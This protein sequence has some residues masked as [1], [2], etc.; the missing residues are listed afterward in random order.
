MAEPASFQLLAAGQTDRGLV[1][2]QNEDDLFIDT[3]RQVFAVA[4]GLGGL[5]EGSLASRTAIESVGRFVASPKMNGSLD[6]EQLF[7]QVNRSVY[8]VGKTISKDFGIGT[9]LTLAHLRGNLLRIG[10]VGDTGVYLLRDGQLRKLTKDH[11]MSQEMRDRMP[12]GRETPIP[13]YYS[14][15]LT[16]C[17][18]LEDFAGADVYEETLEAGDRLLIYSDGLTKVFEEDELTT[19]LAKDQEP[20]RIVGAMIAEANARGGP[21]NITLITLFC[22]A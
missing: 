11:T 1:R 2:A 12:P 22:Q 13:D 9:T 19:W 3:G 4:D 16:R 15:T 7:N 14:H 8:S 17:I 18:G 21:D 20:G 10:H 6:F 5:P